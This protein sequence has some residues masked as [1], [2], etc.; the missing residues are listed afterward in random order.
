MKIA[1]LI[2]AFR[3]PKLLLK[4]IESLRL[5]RPAYVYFA[6]DGGR[7]KHEWEL[8]RET[9]ECTKAIDWD[10]TIVTKF[11]DKNHGAGKWVSGSVSW[12]FEHVAFGYI[13]EEDLEL[14]PSF[15]VIGERLRPLIM[16]SSIPLTFNAFCPVDFRAK[17]K[18]ATF[19]SS[20]VGSWG[21]AT[22]SH[23]WK[24]FDYS[25]K[26]WN[27][28]SQVERWMFLMRMTRS[29]DSALFYFL[30]FVMTRQRKFDVWDHQ[31]TFAVWA[32]G[33]RGITPVYS[34]CRNNGYGEGATHTSAETRLKG[35]PFGEIQGAHEVDLGPCA[36]LPAGDIEILRAITTAGSLTKIPRMIVSVLV[37]R[38]IFYWV[39][40]RF[41]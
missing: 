32:S 4:C 34:L 24:V 2:V 1:I 40:R 8:V 22:S 11:A 27:D 23:S 30:A 21:W 28:M 31:W 29:W 36:E 14:D 3:R 9:R 35:F 6:V 18:P 5:A 7:N 19:Y 20:F 17:C 39:R 25:M 37:P 15:F 38:S 26:A 12:F 41:R 16:S 10:C 33:G 13:I